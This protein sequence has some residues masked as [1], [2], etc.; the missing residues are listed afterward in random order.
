MS[1]MTM[2]GEVTA[3]TDTTTAPSTEVVAPDTST[4]EAKDAKAP[5][6]GEPP[7]APAWTPNFKLKVYDKEME[8]PEDFRPFIKDEK[9]EKKFRELFEKSYALDEH[10]GIHQK[11]LQNLDEFKSKATTHEKELERVTEGVKKLYNY[12]QKDLGTF[13]E[14]YRIPEDRII[15]FVRDRLQ[16]KE[17]PEHERVQ[18]DELRQRARAADQYEDQ[19]RQQQR[20]NQE[21]VMSQHNS[22]ME[23]AMNA[24]DVSTFK[25]DFDTRFGQGAFQKHVSDHGSRIYQ[26]EKKYISPFEATKAVMEYYRP[27]IQTQ[28]PL[29]ANGGQTT[30]QPPVIPNV[31]TGRG[32]S[33]TRPKFKSLDSLKKFVKEQYP[34]A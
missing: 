19:L 14:M 32:V 27:A 6:S 2:P 9:A 11:V 17:L 15:E 18:R 20:Q 24:P 7:V 1:V 21:M 30:E 33:P 26:S 13:F 16:E 12:S 31:G 3:T 10:K 8:I 29:T 23:M 5:V 25:K 34:E 22:A 28:A 4:P